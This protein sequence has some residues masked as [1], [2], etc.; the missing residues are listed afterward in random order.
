M[1]RNIQTALAV[2]LPRDSGSIPHN[3]QILHK[4]SAKSFSLIIGLW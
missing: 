3:F 4:L 2:V 1:N